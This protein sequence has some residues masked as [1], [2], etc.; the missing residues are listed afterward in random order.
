MKSYV[1]RDAVPA[2]AREKLKMYPE[3]LQDMLFYRGIEKAED[4]DAFLNPNYEKHIHDPYLLKDME[5][6]V[7]RILRAI[8]KNER[9]I[10]YT[11]YDADGIPAGVIF[12]DFFKRIGFTNFENYFPHRYEEGYGLNIAAIEKFKES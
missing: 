10:V 4:A 1:V 6:A 7:E 5:K 12:Y 8:E 9:I 3:L 11:D 2:E